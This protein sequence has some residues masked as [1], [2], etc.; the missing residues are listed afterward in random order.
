MWNQQ[1]YEDAVTLLKSL[2]S[3]PS[4]SREEQGTAQLIA[5]FLKERGIPYQ[6][7]LN[8]IWAKNKHFDPSRP[9]IVFN[10]HHDTVKPNPQYTRN[11]FSPD[12]EDGRLY[13]LGSNDA[14]GCLVSLIATF[15][16]FYERADM[17]YNIVLTATAEEEI[18]GA[19]GIESILDQ[20]PKIDF[21]IVGEPTQTQLAIAEKGLMVLDCTVQ[22]NAGHAA[23][24]EGEN[25]LYKALP[26]IEWFRTYRFPKVSET[27]GP[28]K[29]SVTVINTSN[30]AHN[31]VPADCSFVV[32]VR[33]TEQY[34]LE[35]VL[36]IIRSNVKCEVKPRSLRMR[37]SGIPMDHPFVQGGI[38]QGKT[39]YGSPTTSDQALIP[40]TSIKMGPGDSARS[41]TADEYIYLDEVRQGIDS[42]IN[43]LEEIL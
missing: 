29:M 37:P 4:L 35:Q 18:S 43:L 10:S 33:V 2:I 30:K 24:D 40:A 9:V 23:R 26:D 12:V 27:L 41:H 5:E 31:V 11:P 6:Q 32:D 13:G 17:K 28:V 21:A 1:L 19:N 14:G 16:H 20:L 38:R 39:C 15:L 8:N 25:A 7:H 34:T 22:G 3:V 36:D 42:Y